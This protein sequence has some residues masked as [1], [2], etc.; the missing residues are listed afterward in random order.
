MRFV[1]VERSPR[2]ATRSAGTEEMSFW[3]VICSVDCAIGEMVI[4]SFIWSGQRSPGMNVSTPLIFERVLVDEVL[5]WV[6]RRPNKA[7]LTML[8]DNSPFEPIADG[9]IA[10]NTHSRCPTASQQGLIFFTFEVQIK[11]QA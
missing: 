7:Q 3:S 9:F 5:V 4:V 2:T 10:D 11:V 8:R 6:L 1:R